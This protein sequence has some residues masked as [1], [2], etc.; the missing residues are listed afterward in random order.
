MKILLFG[1]R[2]QIGTALKD[3]VPDDYTVNL[4]DENICDTEQVNYMVKANC[5]DVII[6]AAAYTSV[7]MAEVDNECAL[8]TNAFGPS[9]LADIAKTHNIL[10]VHYST[11][12]VYDGSGYNKWRETDITAP[13]NYY[14]L[15]KLQGDKAIM[16]SGCNHLIFRTSWVYGHKGLNF[17]SKILELTKNKNKINVV[18][19]QIGAPSP[20][21]FLAYTTYNAI[22][23]TQDDQKLCGLYHA[24]PSGETSWHEYAQKIIEAAGLQNTIEITPIAT[25][26]EP[27]KARRP[28]NSRLDTSKLT[29]SFGITPPVWQDGVVETVKHHMKF[30]AWH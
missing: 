27:G 16:D 26:Y 15:T 14:G 29:K 9:V 2:G 12:Y 30:T 17:I 4:C 20:A 25:Q 8:K 13:L 7:D 22:R 28:L 6:N 19:D 5:P 24:C 21:L 1:H 11:D 3:S 23:A 18:N 10:L